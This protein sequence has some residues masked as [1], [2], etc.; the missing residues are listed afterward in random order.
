MSISRACRW[1][2]GPNVPDFYD[3]QRLSRSF[4]TLALLRRVRRM[5]FIIDAC[6]AGAAAATI[7]T[8]LFASF[9]SQPQDITIGIVA[10]AFPN[11]EAFAG[12]LARALTD[13]LILSPS[14]KRARG[15]QNEAASGKASRV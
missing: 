8:N 2:L 14:I 7:T 9:F 6:N 3:W 1:K 5:L 13:R 15:C 10:A 11:Q 12:A 4:T